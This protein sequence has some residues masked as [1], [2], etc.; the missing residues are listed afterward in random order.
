MKTGEKLVGE[1]WRAVVG[2]EGRYEVS[3]FGRVRGIGSH[4]GGIK[5]SHA[6]NDGYYQQVCLYVATKKTKS[7]C[8]HALVAEA[9]IGPLPPGQLC[10]HRD[11]DGWHN[12]LS[13]LRYGTPKSNGEDMVRHGNSLLGSRNH[14]AKLDETIVAEIKTRRGVRYRDL[15]QEYGVSFATIQKIMSGEGWKHVA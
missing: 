1:E 9:F 7:V 11:G 15:A 2:F 4:G 3:S 6:S 14:Q 10:C 8:V 5:K 13:N 12:H